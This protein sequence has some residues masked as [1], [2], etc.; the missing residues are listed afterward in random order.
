L[1]KAT[2]P[3]KLNKHE[4]DSETRKKH[5]ND[6]NNAKNNKR[7]QNDTNNAKNNKRQQNAA[8]TTNC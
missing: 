3:H 4:K 6:T 1:K 5:K 8:L 2:K 7:Q